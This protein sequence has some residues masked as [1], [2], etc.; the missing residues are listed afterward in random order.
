MLAVSCGLRDCSIKIV[1]VCQASAPYPDELLKY[2]VR[3]VTLFVCEK[4]YRA[5]VEDAIKTDGLQESS[6]PPLLGNKTG[7]HVI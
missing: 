2:I 6:S 3:L 5:R 1:F 7:H 4:G